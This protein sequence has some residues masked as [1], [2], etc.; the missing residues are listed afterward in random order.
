MLIRRHR[1]RLKEFDN[2]SAGQPD[3]PGGE[4]GAAEEETPVPAPVTFDEIASRGVA[5]ER[6]SGNASKADWVAYAVAQGADEDEANGQ[7]R[8]E[9]RE[10]Y[11]A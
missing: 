4:Q 10:Q 6:P 9:L 1:D 11:G 5:D 2:P 8:D 3:Y 7:S